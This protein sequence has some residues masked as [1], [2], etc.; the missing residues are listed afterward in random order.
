MKAS[1]TCRNG[2]PEDKDIPAVYYFSA[3]TT[4]TRALLP[5]N[6]RYGFVPLNIIQTGSFTLSANTALNINS[7]PVI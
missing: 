4:Q 5:I 3:Y 7:T 6:P 2:P 1:L